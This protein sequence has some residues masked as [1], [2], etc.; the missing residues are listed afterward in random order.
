MYRILLPVGTAEAGTEEAVDTITSLPGTDDLAVV[1]VHVSKDVDL[2]GPDGSH[3]SIDREDLQLPAPVENTVT[4][5]RERGITVDLDVRSD[6][7]TVSGIQKAIE[8]HEADQLVVPARRRSPVGKIVLGSTTLQLLHRSPV[9]V[10][11]VTGS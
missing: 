3:V 7:T 9:P 8:V 2:Y 6:E 10:T 5:L 4:G 11:V 1:V